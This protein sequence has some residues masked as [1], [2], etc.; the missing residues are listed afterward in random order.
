MS[1][2]EPPSLNNMRKRKRKRAV[3]PASVAAAAARLPQGAIDPHSY[4]PATLRQLTLAGLTHADVLPAKVLESFP[5]QSLPDDWLSMLDEYPGDGDEDGNKNGDDDDDSDDNDDTGMDGWKES[6]HS[7][8]DHTD[9]AYAIHGSAGES[10]ADARRRHHGTAAQRKARR[11]LEKRRRNALRLQ[12][13]QDQQVGVLAAIVQRGLQEAE[14]GSGGLDGGEAPI[15]LARALRAFGLLVRTEIK[16]NSV[17]L[18]WNGYWALGAELLM[19]DGDDAGPTRKATT[20]DETEQPATPARHRRWGAAANVGRVRAYYE[21]LIQQHPYNRLWPRSVN[22]LTFW[23]ALLGTE[24]YSIHAEEQLAL[25]RLQAEGHAE[26]GD[27][28]GG[29]DGGNP[30]GSYLQHEG[31]DRMAPSYKLGD[32]FED[33]DDDDD[34]DVDE[35]D[36]TNEGIDGKTRDVQ[37]R[38]RRRR[39]RHRLIRRARAD[40]HRATLAQLRDLARRF[41]ALLANPPYTTSPELLRLRGMLALYTGDVLAAEAAAEEEEEEDDDDDDDAAQRQTRRTRRTQR[42]AVTEHQRQRADERARART[43]FARLRAVET[44][45]LT[46]QQRRWL[47]QSDEGQ[48]HQG[49]NSG[50]GAYNGLAD[51]VGDAYVAALA[52]G[53]RRPR[54]RRKTTKAAKAATVRSTTKVR[55]QRT[56]S[57]LEEGPVDDGEGTA[58]A[59]RTMGTGEDVTMEDDA[60]ADAEVEEEEEDG[61][62]EEYDFERP[63]FTSLAAYGL[64]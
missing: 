48:Q 29:E 47:R 36:D 27:V 21:D 38:L 31:G 60:D 2:I 59:E 44:A 51:L 13:A 40:L 3:R 53:Q 5:H 55:H 34:N 8:E 50:G 17:D 16:G 22:A 52:R 14:H 61:G 6:A 24:L 45:A 33:Y 42:A 56:P 30:T 23:P 1:Y 18:R 64:P 57:L 19:R 9:D 49:D 41:D 4:G 15:G 26:D 10:G 62:D 25:E 20:A 58:Y 43:R 54:P 37:S 7:A 35:G 39:G 46:R 28:Y 32:G 63:V 12:R 11:H